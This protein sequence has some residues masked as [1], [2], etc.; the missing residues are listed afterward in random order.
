MDVM[1][2]NNLL[3]L[4]L[5]YLLGSIPTSLWVGKIFHQIDIREHG[6]KNAGATNTVRVLG[7]KTGI[8]VL[9]F[10][11]FKGWLA[12]RLVFLL[13][14]TG[15]SAPIIIQFQLLFGLIAVLGHLFPVFARFNGGKGIA[16]LF[17]MFLGIHAISALIALGVFLVIF[18]ITRIVSA[19]S[20]TAVISYP[21]ISIWGFGITEP[22]FI[23][24]CL[25]FVA[26]VLL[27]HQS[28]LQRLANGTEPKLKL[29]RKR[30]K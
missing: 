17:G 14:L 1:S 6:S 30:G 5:A 13:P 8:P 12:T 7:A 11:I 27:T 25:L 26:I 20:I 23:G 18:I 19:S 15:N 28:N 2:L 29:S 9:L 21:L 24:I 4:V 16:T 22:L 10:D 3:L